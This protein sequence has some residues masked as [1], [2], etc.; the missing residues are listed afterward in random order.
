MSKK[1]NP[2]LIGLFVIGAV[3]LAAAGVLVFGSGKLLKE[4]RRVVTFFEGSV[5]GL[6][7]GAAVLFRGVPV[8]TVAEV[9]ALVD[10]ESLELDVSVLLELDPGS[11]R[12][13]SG[14]TG[15]TRPVD[16]VVETLVEK[17]LRSKL[18][19]ESLVTGQL[20]VELDFHPGA[21]AVYRAPADSAYPEIP[22][23]PS[24]L[25]RI[26]AMLDGLADRIG[27]LPLEKLIERAVGTLES[28]DRLVNS[29]HVA[30]ILA[31]ADA[32]VNSEDTQGL[33]ADLR[34]A[35]GKLDA[36]LDAA[37]QLVGKAD[38]GLEPVLD[39]L[40]ALVER[41]DGTL[42]EAQ[43]LLG[44]AAPLVGEDSELIYRANATLEETE[45]AM[46]SLRVFLDLLE[47]NP[48]A[49]LRG[50]PKP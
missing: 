16:E 40:P 32:L 15:P 6:K 2:A 19:P 31:G 41:L 17:G 21:A 42:A 34:A 18:I 30:G 22:S 8:G 27:D 26:E 28:I 37:R 44:A 47:R 43:G 38:A 1:A 29:D 11:V 23:V 7:Q 39:R 24:D 33:T 12:D 25:Q 3:A 20:A 9:F 14:G 48:E 50:K 36:T 35:V 13:A 10:R 5:V 49:L 45:A 4:T 46:R